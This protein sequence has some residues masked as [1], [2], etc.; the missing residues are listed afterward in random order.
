MQGEQVSHYRLTEKLGAG[1]YGEVWKGVHVHD[2]QLFVAI[3]LVHSALATDA[4]F[5]KALKA[6]CRVLSRLHHPNIVGFRELALSDAHPPAMVLELVPGGSLE[7]RLASG[8]QPVDAVV[9]I[10][11][12]M[13]AGLGHAHAEGVVHR[14]IKP[15]NVLLDER[16]RLRLVDFGIA[17]AADSGNATK[18]G[19]VQGTL[20]YIAPEVVNG[21]KAGPAADVYAAGLVAWELL[22]GRRACP[23][24]ALG[25]K[26][27]WHIGVGLP[28]VRTVRADCPAWL[29]EVVATLGAKEV[30]VRPVD[31][32]AALALMR[33][34]RSVGDPE[35]GV[36][37]VAP[38]TVEVSTAQVV[39]SLPPQPPSVV[40][41]T[42]SL[43]AAQVVSSLPPQPPS[44]GPGTVVLE[45]GT[46]LPPTSPTR[47][48]AG[49]VAPGGRPGG[50]RPWLL[51]L[52]VAGAM[53][54]MASCL[55]VIWIFGDRSGALGASPHEASVRLAPPESRDTAD[56][57]A[58][59]RVVET[60]SQSATLT[61]NLTDPTVSS[62]IA[63]TCPSGFARR[64]GFSGGVAEVPDVPFEMCKVSFKGGAPAV[65]SGVRGGQT[66]TCS[67]SGG[68]SNCR[69]SSARVRS[70]SPSP[71]PGSSSP[72][73]SNTSA[74]GFP[75]TVKFVHQGVGTTLQCDDGQQSRFVG[76]TRKTFPTVTTCVVLADGK[77]GAV[78]INK[79]GTSTCTLSGDRLRCT[80]P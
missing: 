33:S 68:L 66:I 47:M 19:V 17:R 11:E 65:H 46:S 16:G 21:S 75:A 72:S 10:L 77:K 59:E 6:E 13:L 51:A 9:D 1:T 49:T 4:A 60:E 18:T 37:P 53:L 28:D 29:A 56:T 54:T 30:A 24:G 80:D 15:G 63:V 38:G 64:V 5:L 52:V 55:G 25:T 3:K 14:D 34:R 43:S 23:E 36:A 61:V 71:S 44:T 22:S 69:P 58:S 20:D 76:M 45:S 42:V 8:P 79:S 2:D 31:G 73:S 74:D 27:G 32:A 41:G 50:L 67:P 70:S 35:A 40:P 57:E 62:S 26:L 78:T 7:E 39:S 48:P 12:A